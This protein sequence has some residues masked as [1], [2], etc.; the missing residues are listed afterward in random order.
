[1][2]SKPPTA[3]NTAAILKTSHEVKTGDASGGQYIVKDGKLCFISGK[4]IVVIREHFP[5]S[6]P[7][8]EMLVENMIRYD[9]KNSSEISVENQNHLCYNNEVDNVL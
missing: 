3:Q 1:M 4:N 5:D 7:T 6:G 8:P 2:Q 9:S